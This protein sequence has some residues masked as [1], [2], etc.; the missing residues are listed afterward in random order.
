MGTFQ[1]GVRLVH[2]RTWINWKIGMLEPL[3]LSG[4]WKLENREFWKFGNLENWS[5]V[6]QN[7]LKFK[8]FKNSNAEPYETPLCAGDCA[9][10]YTTCSMF[11]RD[12]VKTC[13]TRGD[14]CM[15]LNSIYAQCRPPDS[16]PDGW[17]GADVAC[18]APP[19]RMHV[20]GTMEFLDSDPPEVEA[21]S[22]WSY[23]LDT[24]CTH[25]SC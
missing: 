7:E 13:C 6:T 14:I 12:E 10:R 20:N 9:P 5:K 8:N 2:T 1:H 21:A 24:V 16:K 15:A 25:Q 11:E 22:H 3:A 19:R 17:S 4:D 18:Q 23:E